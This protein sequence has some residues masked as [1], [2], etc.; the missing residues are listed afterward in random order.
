MR[1]RAAKAKPM[2]SDVYR[3]ITDRIVRDLERGV[4]PW[5]NPWSADNTEGRIIRPL[6]ANGT[7]YRGINVLMLWSVAVED[8]FSSPFWMTNRQAI[9]LNAHVRKGA[10]GTLVVYSD[11][12]VRTETDSKTGE[13]AEREIPFMKGYTVF[14]CD[15]IEGL[16]EHYYA[17]PAPRSETMQRI[18]R[19][20]AFFAA[21]G[22]TIRH[23]GNLAF[24]TPANDFVQMPPFEAFRDAEAYYATLAHE[25]THWTRHPARLNRD[26]GRK[27][28]GDAGYAMEEL[29]AELCS[30]FLSADLEL[31]PEVREDH[32]SYL[33]SWIDVL[34]NDKRAIFSAA[35]YAQRA[36]DFLHNL[37][38]AR[39]A[40]ANP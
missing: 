19:A 14:N 12:I 38:K 29:V 39:A 16:P 9:E 17:K 27:R 18:A 26:F 25:L 15:Q 11:R 21:T 23:G 4:R 2:K 3:T 5:L 37:Q 13:E 31:T 33:A 1:N 34:K 40:S 35:S 10:C 28:W 7:P 24:Y 30:A 6:R 22:A 20:D 8:G 36:A 32:A